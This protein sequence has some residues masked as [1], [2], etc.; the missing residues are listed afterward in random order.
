MLT[1]D[2]GDEQGEG[3]KAHQDEAVRQVR[4]RQPP[5][6]HPVSPGTLF[7]HARLQLVRPTPSCHALRLP[8]QPYLVFALHSS[9]AL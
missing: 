5:H 9:F 1:G 8:R 3:D 4:Q 2:E 6:A 7:R